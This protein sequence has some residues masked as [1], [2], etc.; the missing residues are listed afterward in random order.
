[1]LPR[2]QMLLALAIAA[3]VAA[4]TVTSLPALAGDHLGGMPLMLHMAAH[5]GQGGNAFGLS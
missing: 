3:V 4:L 1:M 5:Y 2:L